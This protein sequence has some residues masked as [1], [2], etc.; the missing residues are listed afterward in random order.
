M[1]LSEPIML[2]PFFHR[3]PIRSP[4][5]F[6]DRHSVLRQGTALLNNGQSISVVGPRRIGKTSFLF[7]LRQHLDAD[8]GMVWRSGYLDCGALRLSGEADLFLLLHRELQQPDD[9]PV[10]FGSSADQAYRALSDLVR[11]GAA[12]GER[13]VLFLDEFGALGDNPYLTRETF[14]AL[15]GLVMSHGLIF[16][17]ASIQPLMTL[18]FAHS[19]ALS[20]PFFNFFAQLRLGPFSR[21]EAHAMLCDQA[22]LAEVVLEDTHAQFLL[23]L[24]GAHPLLL[25]IAGYHAVEQLRQGAWDIAAVSRAFLDDVMPHWM[26]FWNVL[27][28]EDQRLLA[29]LPVAWRGDLEGAV[30]LEQAGLIQPDQEGGYRPTSSY[31]QGFVARQRV[32]GLLQAPPITIDPEQHVILLRGKPLA[33]SPTEFRLLTYLVERAGQIVPH[34]K[35]SMAVWGDTH[36]EPERLRVTMRAL[37]KA[38][39][40]DASCIDNERGIGYRFVRLVI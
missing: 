7:R 25:Q 34:D 27:T 15:R 28:P 23:D 1:L 4:Q 39:G 14:S 13:H 6:F 10:A 21:E 3:G 18:D 31:F 8:G 5:G 16:V 22:A 29:L 36:G 40:E 17:T 12:R 32:E 20:S 35:L 24:S 37:R 9:T 30:R 2:N 26:Y 33:I 38:L 19:D 11:V